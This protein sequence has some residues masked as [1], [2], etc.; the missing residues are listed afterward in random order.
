MTFFHNVT[1][2]GLAHLKEVVHTEVATAA[3]VERDVYKAANRDN[4]VVVKHLE[5][6]SLD[7]NGSIGGLTFANSDGAA[8]KII[9]LHSGSSGDTFDFGRGFGLEIIRGYVPGSDAFDF[10]NSLFASYGDMI[11]HA[12]QHGTNVAIAYDSSDIITLT[13]VTLS[14]LTTHESDFHFV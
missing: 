12:K 5:N 1:A 4:E 6:G 3:Y 11:S 2:F 9:E 10:D 14:Q 13:H 8:I 7:V